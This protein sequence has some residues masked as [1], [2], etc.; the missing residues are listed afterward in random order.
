M[1]KLLRISGWHTIYENNR[2]KELKNMSWVP[3]PNRMDGDGY[4]EFLDHKEG[5]SHFGAWIAMLQIASRCDPRGTLMRD[6]RRPH[7]SESMSRISRMPKKLFDEAIPRLIEIGWIE[8]QVMEEEQLTL[9][10]QEGAILP[11]EDASSRAGAVGKRMEQKEWNRT[12]RIRQVAQNIH[13]RHPAHGCGMAEIQKL[14]TEIL[15]RVPDAAH[16]HALKSIDLNHELWCSTDNWKRGYSRGLA[17]WLAPTKDRWKDAPPQS[18]F[19]PKTNG[20]GITAED[21]A[22]L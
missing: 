19:S 16:E 7:T 15:N 14:L 1:A 10:P 20:R 2:T 22:A 3:I 4:T 8:E 11:Q 17:N 5:A 12:E 6:G 9:A 21:I 13:D 18:E